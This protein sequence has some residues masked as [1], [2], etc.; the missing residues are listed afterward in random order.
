MA[1]S[2]DEIPEETIEKKNVP[3]GYGFHDRR[4]ELSF[5]YR[6]PEKKSHTV[7]PPVARPAAAAQAPQFA[8]GDHV[9]HKAFGPGELVNMTPMG[10]DYLIEIRFEQAG[11]KKLMLRAAAPHMTKS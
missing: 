1:V 11:L 2:V 4:E 5:A 3:K 10:G 7:R 6:A 8:V 9:V